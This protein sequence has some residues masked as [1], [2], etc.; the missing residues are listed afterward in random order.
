MIQNGTFV[1]VVGHIII[2]IWRRRRIENNQYKKTTGCCC[3]WIQYFEFNEFCN[4]VAVV[5]KVFA[6]VSLNKNN[7]D[8]DNGSLQRIRL[9]EFKS[10]QICF[11]GSYFMFLKN[12]RRHFFVFMRISIWWPEFEL[13]LWIFLKIFFSIDRNQPRMRKKPR[14]LMPSID[15]EFD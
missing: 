5:S 14:N 10:T 8:V 3:L 2:I 7:D 13:K 4:D 1:V 11:N 12:E 9:K 6:I 15:I